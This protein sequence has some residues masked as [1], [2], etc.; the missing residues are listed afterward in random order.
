MPI[1]IKKQPLALHTGSLNV[2]LKNPISVGAV[3]TTKKMNE[4]I[5]L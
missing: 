2:L 3:G 5:I 4:V 1:A